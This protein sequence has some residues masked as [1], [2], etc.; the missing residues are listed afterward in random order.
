MTATAHRTLD[1][2][3]LTVA[4]EDDGDGPAVMLLHGWPTSSLLYRDIAPVL[5]HDHRV[6]VPDLPGFGR[7][8]KPLDRPYTFEFFA[9]VL[10]ALVDHLGLN[11]F[12]LVVHDLGGSIGV[13]WALHRPGLISR[14][15]VLNTLLYP[16][17][18]PSVFEFVG[19]LL[20]ET[21][22]AVAVSDEGLQDIF[23]LGLAAPG[24]VMED[25][26]AGIVA[27][28][29]SDD[30]RNAL[31]AAAIG[32]DPAGFTEIARLLPELTIPVLGLY[33][34][35][36]RILPD[37]ADTFARLQRDIP[38]ADVVALE[39]AGHFL[40]EDRPADVAARLSAFFA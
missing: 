33:G 11:H 14:L 29:R 7:S 20:H 16:E 30:D 2:G 26:L 19:Q 21:S 36:D 15:A 22:R 35:D 3:G 10:D 32:L 34:T 12:G 39:G 24:A 5:A 8:S 25:V 31:A 4:Y 38:H 37:V 6:V 27:P 18:D 40:Q 17:F 1:I 13:H 23:R 9:G 28:F